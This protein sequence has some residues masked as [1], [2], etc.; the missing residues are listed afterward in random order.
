MVVGV[1]SG[2]FAKFDPLS[3]GE[4]HRANLVAEEYAVR[5]NLKS[6]NIKQDHRADGLKMLL[7]GYPSHG[8]VIDRCESKELFKNVSPP[9]G[10]VAELIKLLGMGVI[11]PRNADRN[12]VPRL[13][14]LNEDRSGEERTANAEGR[15]VREQPSPLGPPTGGVK[16]IRGHFP[17]GSGK[18][19]EPA[20]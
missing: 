4:D 19:R 20:A 9:E 6:R 5:L 15:R 3:I 14:F 12:E 13:E 2:I 17:A 18:G 7:R 8:F 16:D 10:S 1:T 11:M